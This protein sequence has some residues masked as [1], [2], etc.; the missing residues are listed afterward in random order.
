MAVYFV[1]W[2]SSTRSLASCGPVPS[3]ALAPAGCSTAKRCAVG[4]SR[5]ANAGSRWLSLNAFDQQVGRP[6]QL[7]DTPWISFPPMARARPIAR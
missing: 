5:N 7:G 3:E 4:E 6:G 2:Q 1:R